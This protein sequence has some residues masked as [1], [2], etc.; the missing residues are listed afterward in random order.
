MHILLFSRKTLD[1]LASY[2][3]NV[4]E[5]SNKEGALPLLHLVHTNVVVQKAEL[6]L[7]AEYAAVA[8]DDDKG[9]VRAFVVV[10]AARQTGRARQD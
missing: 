10:A 3:F 5:V 2:G 4:Q 7:H 9:A 1:N 6:L 8:A